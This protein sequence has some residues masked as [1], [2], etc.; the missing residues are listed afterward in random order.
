[1]NSEILNRAIQF[2]KFVEKLLK[3]SY[4]NPQAIKYPTDPFRQSLQYDLKI[5]NHYIEIKYILDGDYKKTL[6]Y[7]N[8]NVHVLNNIK[9]DNLFLFTNVYYNTDSYEFY[10]KIREDFQANNISLICI[11]D[12][13]NVVYSNEELLKELQFIINYSLE[14]LTCIGES[15]FD[16]HF[17]KIGLE[18]KTMTRKDKASDLI[19]KLT[20]LESGMQTYVYYEDLCCE[21]IEY[22]FSDFLIDIRKQK[23]INE[24][25]NRTDI[26]AR[27]K[28]NNNIEFYKLV[29]DRFFSNFIVFECKNYSEPIGQNVIYITEKYL[30]QKALRNVVLLL[31]RKGEMDSARKAREEVL[32]ESGKLIIVL[33]DNDI[34]KM[35]N[36]KKDKGFPEDYLLEKTYIYLLELGK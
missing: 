32:R 6:R 13:L 28:G 27:I 2:E 25:R 22:L 34:I 29:Y 15:I 36:I 4:N 31:T 19:K 3:Y 9:I 17:L 12:I 10:N 18:E 8:L 33:E 24:N 23:G 35:L 7:R 30:Y 16:R 14:G 1:M 21:I 26:I 11:N 20:C 5:D